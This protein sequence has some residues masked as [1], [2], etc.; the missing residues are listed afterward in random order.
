MDGKDLLIWFK[1]WHPELVVCHLLVVGFNKA[2]V[3]EYFDPLRKELTGVNLLNKP[4]NVYNAEK[5]GFHLNNKSP[6]KVFA[7]K[8]A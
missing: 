1:V 5:S 4:A 6:S 3:S 2:E 7:A 8:W